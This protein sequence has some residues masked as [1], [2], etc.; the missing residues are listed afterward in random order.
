MSKSVET[1]HNGYNVLN[2]KCAKHKIV[3]YYDELQPRRTVC[4]QILV[5]ACEEK[6]AMDLFAH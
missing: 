6:E 2:T 1:G 3:K 5:K 4:H